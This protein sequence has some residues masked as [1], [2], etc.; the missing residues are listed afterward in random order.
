[1]RPPERGKEQVGS[2][3]MPRG[4]SVPRLQVKRLWGAGD[5]LPGARPVACP[6][7]VPPTAPTD[8]GWPEEGP[9]AAPARDPLSLPPPRQA[10]RLIGWLDPHLH[11]DWNVQRPPPSVTRR[12]H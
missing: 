11:L 9:K 12:G 1:M 2:P 8:C 10:S 6:V 4:G 7:P 5:A 3:R